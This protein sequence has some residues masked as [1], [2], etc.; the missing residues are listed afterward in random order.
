MFAIA[1]AVGGGVADHLSS[2]GFEDPAAESTRAGRLIDDV[3]GAGEP[4]LVLLVTATRGDVDAPAVVAAGAA[5]T[6]ELAAT[7]GIEQ[8]SSYWSLGSVPPL[9]SGDGHQALVL[10][11]IAGDED[12][13]STRIE[14]LSP[15]LTRTTPELDVRV[16]GFAEVFRQVTETVESDLAKAEGVALP[17]GPARR[18]GPAH[19]RQQPP[20]AGRDPGQLR[21]ERGGRP[22]RRGHRHG[23]PEPAH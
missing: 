20:G 12:T 14:E 1:G 2:G 16:G 9:R 15:H 4:N 5:L 21:L 17:A 3:F 10:A 22:P 7:E 13:V 18:P 6:A 19:Q 11:R 23:R 8:A